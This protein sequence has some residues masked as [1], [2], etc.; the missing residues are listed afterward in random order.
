MGTSNPLV[1]ETYAIRANVSKGK[2]FV[3][4]KRDAALAMESD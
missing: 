3:R 2:R 4:E 1:G